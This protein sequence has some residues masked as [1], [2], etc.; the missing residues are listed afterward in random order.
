MPGSV[1]REPQPGRFSGS[2]APRS[3][4]PVSARH[5]SRFQPT[6]R[7]VSR[8]FSMRTRVGT[9]STPRRH[10]ASSPVSSRG[11]APAGKAGSSC[12]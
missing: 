12:E 11:A 8:P 2:S 1:V 7:A 9:I 4:R 3:A 10:D 5:S 6:Q